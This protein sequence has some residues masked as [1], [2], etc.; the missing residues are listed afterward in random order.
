MFSRLGPA[1][2]NRNPS[3]QSEIVQLQLQGWPSTWIRSIEP[4]PGGTHH[5]Q[6]FLDHAKQVAVFLDMQNKPSAMSW[7]CISKLADEPC[8]WHHLPKSTCSRAWLCFKLFLRIITE[9]VRSHT[10][11]LINFSMTFPSIPAPLDQFSS[12]TVQNTLQ[13]SSVWLLLQ[14]C[15]I[16]SSVQYCIFFNCALVMDVQCSWL[17]ITE[18]NEQTLTA[19]YGFF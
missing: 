4:K 7:R 1:H 16:A 18:T 10:Q 11:M 9:D 19:N 5:H 12:S 13:I 2:G 14:L 8:C 15:R 17:R 6:I 3:H